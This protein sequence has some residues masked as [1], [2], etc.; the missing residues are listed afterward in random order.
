[1]FLIKVV[2]QANL[3]KRETLVLPRVTKLIEINCGRLRRLNSR[4]SRE[5][6]RERERERKIEIEKEGREID[7]GEESEKANPVLCCFV[8]VSFVF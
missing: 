8:L 2:L 1:M 5:R 7:R 4:D 3:L 6:E